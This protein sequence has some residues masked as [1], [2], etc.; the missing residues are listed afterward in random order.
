M[1]GVLLDLPSTPRVAAFDLDIHI[2]SS[3]GISQKNSLFSEY[4]LDLNEP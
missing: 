3:L 1:L 2:S 4:F